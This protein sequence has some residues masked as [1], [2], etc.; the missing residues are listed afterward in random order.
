[1][2]RHW[3]A[4][5]LAALAPVSAHGTTFV[6]MEVPDLA[7]SAHV[8]AVG[9]VTAIRSAA[10]LDGRVVTR[11][12]VRVDEA[13]KGR[14]PSGPLTLEE[15]GGW[16][17]GARRVVEGAPSY[18]VG[19]RV[20][21]FARR[22]R[23]GALHTSQLAMGKFTVFDDPVTGRRVAERE[24]GSAR[25][26]GVAPGQRPHGLAPR[27]LDELR[28]EIRAS[29]TPDGGEPEPS[30]SVPE[31]PPIATQDVEAFALLPT[32]AR[33]F[34]A[35]AGIPVGYHVDAAGDPA[36]G[37]A[38]S[39][40]V[41]EDGM[42][43]WSEIPTA[44]IEVVNVGPTTATGPQFSVCDGSSK[45]VFAD[46]FDEI[47]D[48]V[49]CSGV[50]ALGG[51]CHTGPTGEINGVDFWRRT[52]GDV[53]FADGWAPTCA[54]TS[55]CNF[56]E[57]ATH[58]I[59]HTIGL[60]HTSENPAEADPDLRDA[61]MY[62]AA[63]FDGR[64]ASLRND[65]VAGATFIYPPASDDCGDGLLDGSEECDDG[66]NQGGDGCSAF[67][68]IE[69][70]FGCTGEPSVCAPIC[71]DGLVRGGEVCDDGNASSGD[72]CSD[73]CQIEA[74]FECA[75]EPSEC[76]RACPPVPAGTCTPLG[77]GGRASLLLK[78]RGAN[79]PGVGDRVVFKWLRGPALAQADFGDPRDGSGVH[80][81]LYEDS[82]A[83]HG[84]VLDLTVAS[85]SR[86]EEIPGRG[87]AYSDSAETWDG[88]S[89]IVERGGD[90]GSSKVFVLGRDQLPARLSS[91][92]SHGTSVRKHRK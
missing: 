35:D 78:D 27:D 12:S 7:R 81:C 70:G 90:E 11:V 87:Y 36:L 85:A 4:F 20:L 79:G 6:L 65:D 77:V 24:L 21:V 57:V 39:T 88:V 49:G 1:M 40:Q 46:P 28:A 3:V 18:R 71:S 82:G 32:P 14:I 53:L 64:C 59:G 55:P 54:F 92:L 41:V 80:V 56:A 45:V 22:G 9:E 44:S 48:P 17:G 33:W 13:L 51:G 38:V 2:A 52:E 26:L 74:G 76:A 47:D 60:G 19:E 91:L 25:V 43:A 15:P 75:G 63:H 16:I 23:S 31:L 5:L 68:Q 89:K 84:L 66:G 58:E 83:G 73:L 61:T 34:E 72:G 86:W 10:F 29:L 37:A 69:L 30:A 50:L 42:A 67:C 8:I 62:F